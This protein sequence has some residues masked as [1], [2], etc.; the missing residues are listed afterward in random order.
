M[1]IE[2]IGETGDQLAALH[3]LGLE[4]VKRLG[5]IRPPLAQDAVESFGWSPAPAQPS[6]DAPPSFHRP[7]DV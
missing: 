5:R 2:R 4:L 7:E 6:R 3:M 1:A